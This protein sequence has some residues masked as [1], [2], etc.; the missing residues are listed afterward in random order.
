MSLNTLLEIK[1]PEGQCFSVCGDTHGQYYDVLN[2]FEKI[3]GFPSPSN[4]YLFNGDYVDRGSW[5]CEL[6]ITFFAF[7]ILYPNDF[8]L[9][10]GNHE[11]ISLNAMYG[12]EGE[13]TH[14]YNKKMFALF[15]EVFN[16][17]PLGAVLNEKVFVVHGGLFEKDD[18]TLDD[19]RKIDRNCQPPHAGLMTDMLWSD[20]QPFPGRSQNKRGV[21]IA[22]GPDVT[23]RFL[24]KNN[25]DLVVRSHEVKE[26]GYLVE[27]DGKLITIFSAPNYCDQVGNKG[28]LIRFET[29]EMKPKF[30]QFQCVPHPQTKPLAYAN[31]FGMF[32]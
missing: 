2:I 11:T 24:E 29:K 27:A 16:W 13:V 8:H 28:A 19:I 14:K 15:S 18:V 21:G 7:K 5:S 6:A 32:N 17:L 25:L 3:N 12:F 22:F 26:E 4:P 9:L 10:R 31:S 1:I 30:V 20:P 23:K